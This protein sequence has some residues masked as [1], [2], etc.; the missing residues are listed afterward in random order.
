MAGFLENIIT[1]AVTGG[2]SSSSSNP[3]DSILG[4]VIGGA[5]SSRSSSSGQA[6]ILGKVLRNATGGSSKG[7]I[8]LGDL[9]KV[10]TG[11]GSGA[12]TAAIDGVDLDSIIKG[13]KA[14][15]VDLTDILG[16]MTGASKKSSGVDLGSIL[17][18][19]AGAGVSAV[20]LK[21]ILNSVLS[22]QSSRSKADGGLGDI[23]KSVINVIGM[24]SGSL[25]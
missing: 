23:A 17:K 3:L 6:D 1:S 24:A 8:D 21:K 11:G 9:I 12:S 22:G 15:G 14:N 20:V 5:T 16:G 19:A 18:K 4:S 10:A 7:G 25:K 13:G 2:K